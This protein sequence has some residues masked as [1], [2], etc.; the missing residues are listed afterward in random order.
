MSKKEL[1]LRIAVAFLIISNSWFW[2]QIYPFINEEV[3]NVNIESLKSLIVKSIFMGITLSLPF[4]L[5][6][7]FQSKKSS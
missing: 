6:K 3:I 2:F 4:G 7:Y 1:V 5:L